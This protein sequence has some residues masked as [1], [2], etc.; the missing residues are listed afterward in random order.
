MKKL[1][2]IPVDQI[3]IMIMA[4]GTSSRIVYIIKIWS[5]KKNY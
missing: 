2:G 3:E 4:E 1:S 5:H